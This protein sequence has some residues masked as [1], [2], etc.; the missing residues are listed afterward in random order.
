MAVAQKIGARQYLECSAK[1]GDGVQEVF[2]YAYVTCAKLGSG[3]SMSSL[4]S[5]LSFC[6]VS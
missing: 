3:T 5:K 2:R 4:S 1:T 6:M